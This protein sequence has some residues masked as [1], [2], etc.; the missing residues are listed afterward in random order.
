MVTK[1]GFKV[2]CAYKTVDNVMYAN[3]RPF[4]KLL[5]FT[6]CEQLKSEI[7]STMFIINSTSASE[8]LILIITLM[9][10]S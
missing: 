8:S 5:T 6:L 10:K 4:G 3:I 7:I 2:L 1:R 9:S